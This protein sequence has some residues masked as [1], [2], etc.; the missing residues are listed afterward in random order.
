MAAPLPPRSAPAQAVRQL[1]RFQLLRLLGKSARSMAWLVADPRTGLEMVLLLPRAQP[2]DASALQRWLDSARRASRIDHPGLVAA[3]EVG[4]HDRWPYL[5]YDRGTSVTLSE[6][7]GSKGLPAADLVPSVSQVLQGLAFAHEAGFAHHDVQAMMLVL[8][9][10]G[11][12]SLMGL[13]VVQPGATEGTDLPTQRR[14]AER[15]V[16]ALGLVL[17][18]ALAGTPALEQADTAAVIERMPP[19]GREIVRLPWTGAHA[20][21]EPL[22]AIVNRATDRQERQ[23]YR[24]ARTLERAL[25][26]WLRTDGQVGGGPIML[27]LDRMRAAGLLPAMPGGASRAAR[28]ATLERERSSELA[29]VVL[30]DI[31]LTFELLRSVNSVAARGA[32]GDGNGPILTMRRAI[33]MLGVEGVRRAASTLRAWPGPLGEP[34]AAELAA[35]IDRVGLA[36]RVA[37]WLRPAGY[38]PEVVYLL[39]LLQNLGRLSVQYHFPDEAVQIRKLML[40]APS[41][42]QGEAEEPGMGEEAAS[43]AVLGVDIDV[44][45]SAVA[46]HWGLDD[47]VVHMIR[48]VPWAAPVHSPD[49]DDDLLR[50]TAS[51]ANEVVDANAVPPHHRQAWLQRVMQRYGRV[52]GVTLR[53][54]QLAAQGIAPNEDAPEQA[55][56]AARSAALAGTPRS[57]AAVA[58]R[59]GDAGGAGG[60]P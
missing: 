17:H 36:G 35:L 44:L 43:F 2:A 14:A 21:P 54:L 18:H 38:D 46:R 49:G 51:C 22:R 7:L 39:A 10:S 42:R 1:G 32:L 8:S 40:P 16:L 29:N 4:E 33:E 58:A 56:S 3:V 30:Q 52:L 55:G 9:E 5:A 47:R 13:G 15:D 11:Q 31:G 26:G 12:C 24:N 50:L 41:T 57:L 60:A 20:I 48:R 53:D 6:R 19:L 27:L 37:Q 45:G 23:R 28:L 25:D 59:A 34:Q